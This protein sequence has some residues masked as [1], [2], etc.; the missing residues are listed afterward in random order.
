VGGRPLSPVAALFDAVAPVYET[1]G[2]PFF[3]HFGALLV[4]QAAVGRG[5][6]VLDLAAGTG[7]VAVPALAAVG[8]S[9]SLLAL[10]LAPG[11]VERLAARLSSTDHPAA[12]AV[13]GD[14]A[15]PD[16]APG[17]FDVAL[18]GFALFFLPDPVAAL[19]AWRQAVRPGGTVAVSTW[20]REDEVFGALRDALAELGVESRPRGEAFDDPAVL[21]GALADAGL[22]EVTVS[23]LALDLQLPD[24]DVLLQWAGT[25]G[26][27][28]WTAQLDHAGLIRL[29]R[30][31]RERWPGEVRMTWHAHLAV[32]TR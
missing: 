30:R 17:S 25:H 24:V 3:D 8:A 18:C 31:L 1:V 5:D 4:E 7:A 29:A 26:G 13:V 12:M 16:V 15:S 23:T 27:R 19:R 10:D 20:G 14:A 28:A 21:V 2:P 32:G 6:R 11:M 9:G 22:T